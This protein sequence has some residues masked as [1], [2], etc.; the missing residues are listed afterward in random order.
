MATFDY[1][2]IVERFS[3]VLKSVDLSL[4]QAQLSKIQ[5]NNDLSDK[6]KQNHI[7]LLCRSKEYM[8]YEWSNLSGMLRI[9]FLKM[10]IPSKFSEATKLMKDNLHEGYYQFVME[11]SEFLDNMVKPERDYT[12]NIFSAETLV[13]SYL[14]RVA[15]G[16][17]IRI[18]E[19]PQYMYLR[20][21][22]FMWFE[23]TAGWFPGKGDN[24]RIQSTYDD[25]SLGNYSH[26]SPTLFNSG[27]TKHQLASCFTKTIGDSMSDI[28]RS[29]KHVAFIS[30]DSGGLGIDFSGI[31]HSEIRKAGM[32]NGVIPWI[33]SFERILV[34][35][36]QCFDPDT[37]VYTT[38]KGPTRICKIEIGDT[39]LR[40]D[41]LVSPVSKVIT[42]DM[43][44]Q[45]IFMYDVR[46]VGDESSVDVTG[47]HPMLTYNFNVDVFNEHIFKDLTC[48]TEHHALFK[49]E[50]VPV[51]KLTENSFVAFPIPRYSENP[52]GMTHT[53]MKMIGLVY[54]LGSPTDS[55]ICS[56]VPAKYEHLWKYDP[57]IHDLQCY[58][59]EG[60][61][62]FMVDGLT[63]NPNSFFNSKMKRNPIPWWIVNLP[64]DLLEGF[65]KGLFHKKF[66][67]K[68]TSDVE[69]LKYIFMKLKYNFHVANE[70]KSEYCVYLGIGDYM[71]YTDDYLW[72]KISSI[73]S[74]AVLVSDIY[75]LEMER[76]S[77]LDESVYA[78]YTTNIGLA[79]NGGRRKGSGTGY[80]CDWHVD[81]E[82]FLDLKKPEGAEDLRAR[83]M[84]FAVNIHDEL[85]R[86]ALKDEDWTLFCPNKAKNLVNVWGEEFERLYHEYERLADTGELKPFKK[87][88]ARDL[89]LKIYQ[90]QIESGNP[91]ILFIDEA[92]RKS[93]QQNLGCTRLSNLCMEILLYSDKQNI[94]TCILAAVNLSKC[95]DKMTKTVNY[96]KIESLSRSLVQNLNQVIDRTYYTKKIPQIKYTNFRNRPLGIGYMGLADVIAMMD[97]CWDDPDTAEINRAISETMYYASISESIELAK[98]YGTYETFVGSPASNGMFQFDLWKNEQRQ[99]IVAGDL[100][101]D[102]RKME[103][104][105]YNWGKLREDMVRFGLR[106]SLLIALMPTASSA[107]ILGTNESFEPYTQHIFARTVLGG[108]FIVTNTHLVDDLCEIGIWNTPTVKSIMES[109]G[110][111][112]NIKPLS[113]YSSKVRA[114]LEYLKKKYLTVYELSQRVLQDLAIDRAPFVCQTQS[115]NCW[116][117]DPTETKL[118]AFLFNQWKHGVKTG[119]YYLR[120]PAR[121]NPIDHTTRSMKI[122]Q[123][124]NLIKEEYTCTSCNV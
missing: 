22:C 82:N 6:E 57:E 3:S 40:S 54:F 110:S 76:T 2:S 89:L 46:L 79:H 64:N 5:D 84:T 17:S 72:R 81:I 8:H 39:L 18:L 101:G 124:R 96:S 78:N 109:E 104:D 74:R 49:P 12:F 100:T 113:F 27:T 86:R 7:V 48:S 69:I 63:K 66:K 87:I 50:Y 73:K 44:G 91:F 118:N 61:S 62:V 68:Y 45:H 65:V 25:L 97:L 11:N 28:T 21:A 117:K 9:H 102:V 41:G 58:V 33:K 71:Y 14:G 32:S 80:L 51:E 34:T 83:D 15:D 67:T 36:N 42:H 105:V 19:T 94:G 59:S 43:T 116:M 16:N 60:Q 47:K 26:A 37:I 75:D 106:N 107:H 77:D 24:S 31:R 114:R 4:I 115:Y 108:Q 29:W 85:M 103:T 99:R 1:N 35:V 90:S 93:N 95:V 112:Q 10:D 122:S 111:I 23:E 123:N 53:D 52:Y 70:N 20:V 30:K 121:S 119:V 120:Q 92:N 13:N 98:I 38:N 88:K 56:Q 55:E